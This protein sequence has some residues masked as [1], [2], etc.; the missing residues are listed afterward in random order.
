MTSTRVVGK[1]QGYLGLP[2]LDEPVECSVN[3]TTM[4]TVSAWL[5]TPAEIEAIVA[6]A[7]VFVQLQLHGT[8][9]PPIF[10]YAGTPPSMKETPLAD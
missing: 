7:P 9:H 8:P 10:V 4:I 6:G 2:V 3:G 5:P 1:G